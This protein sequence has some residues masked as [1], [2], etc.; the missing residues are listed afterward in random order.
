VMAYDPT[1]NDVLISKASATTI[2]LEEKRHVG[3]HRSERD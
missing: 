2:F 3:N 1:V